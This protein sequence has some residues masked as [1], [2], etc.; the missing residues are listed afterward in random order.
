MIERII[1][2]CRSII[3]KLLLSLKRFP[4]AIVLVATIVFIIIF[5]NHARFLQEST[6]EILRRICLIL[7]LG[8]P[9]FLSVRVLFEKISS[10][11]KRTKVLIYA[12][13]IGGLILYFF[14]LLQDLS[15]VSVSRYIAF[16]ICFY[17]I[18]A[19][20]PYFYKREYFELYII[21]LFKSFFITYLFS[22]IIYTG[23][24]AMLFTIKS[25]F[26]INISEKVY[27]DSM[28]I[29]AGIF[30]P[31]FFLADIPEYDKKF[32]ADNYPKALKV[33][34]IY[35]LVPI[36]VAYSTILYAYFMK[37]L[38]TRQWPK[39][40][41]SKL[42]LWYSII[43]TII[44]FFIYP[45]RKMNKWAKTFISYFTIA[46]IP[47]L[48]MMFVSMIIRIKAYGITENRYFVI[49]AGLWVTGCMIYFIFAKHTRNIILP[50]S[51]ALISI[52]SVSGPWSC[53]SV[54]KLSQNI[55]FEKI[56]KK[57][58]MIK[59]DSIIKLNKDLSET[60][61]KEISGIIL[62]F[63][64]YHDLKDLK[65]LPKDFKISQMKDVF[66]FQ[67]HTYNNKRDKEYFNY[68]ALENGEF[69][70]I[71]NFDYFTYISSNNYTNK[72][73]SKEELSV[74]YTFPK[75]ELK[76]Y[77]QGKLIYSRNVKD[78]SKELRKKYRE[79]NQMKMNE[80]TI[81]DQTEEVN[82][83]YV[84]KHI[85]GFEDKTTNEININ[86]LDF[87]LFIKIHDKKY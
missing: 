3:K 7:A 19:F 65:Y 80:M 42:V 48:G 37:I 49:I 62:Y 46:I 25:L 76:I 1:L 41:V 58:D 36:I 87:Y 81:Y 78:L 32:N 47:L 53:Y 45:L 4:E 17:C 12:G 59:N 55:R 6:S 75:M 22:M 20:I 83:L 30:A 74:V 67:L 57:N 52:L 82:V 28:L 60:D 69:L 43:S 27:F 50:I 35:I 16:S 15:K 11:K 51:L 85:H 68:Y 86:D 44:I 71:K 10:L 66:G 14:L 9:V 5:M 34:L 84:F 21:E 63:N 31:A 39:G 54:S 64:K 73:P 70:D 18:F 23:F 79:K 38:V 13:A 24:I 72:N 56:L 77:K 33:L 26:S 2:F 8:I 61:K 40:I 29:V